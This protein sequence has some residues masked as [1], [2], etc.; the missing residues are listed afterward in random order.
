MLLTPRE[1]DISQLPDAQRQLDQSGISST[2]TAT[3]LVL[4]PKSASITPDGLPVLLIENAPP[5]I[6]TPSLKLTRPEIYYGE[7]THEPVFVHTAQEEF[8]YPS[9][10]DNV[11]S[12]YEG[13]GGFPI[14]SF[15]D[16]PG[17][18]GARGRAQHPADRSISTPNSR[19]M[20]R[21]KVRD[22]LQEAGRV[23]RLGH[24]TRTW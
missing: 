5:E 14:S 19:M 22:R 20:I 10:E 1:L 13:K 7:V 9:G 8:N 16:A 11:R 23:H 6:K 24:A 15:L 18:R 21:R 3:A 2:P 12:R 4:A 17:G